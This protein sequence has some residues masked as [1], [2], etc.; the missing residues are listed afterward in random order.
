[1]LRRELARGTKALDNFNLRFKPHQ[2]YCFREWFESFMK[3]ALVE[4]DVCENKVVWP[5]YYSKGISIPLSF[6]D[7]RDKFEEAIQQTL[8]VAADLDDFNS[9]SHPDQ[10]VLQLK[11][12]TLKATYGQLVDLAHRRY[13]D[14]E[15]FWP[16]NYQKHGEVL[17][18]VSDVF[19]RSFSQLVSQVIINSSVL[20]LL[21]S[22][23]FVSSGAVQRP[24]GE[25]RRVPLQ[26]GARV[27]DDQPLRAAR[28]HGDRR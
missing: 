14:E 21:D 1:M 19:H 25:N 11:V 5:F 23:L 13:A 6:I 20:C 28:M 27:L 18:L 8:D 3:Q 4:H 2:A 17:T 16:N 26:T 10:K 15:R 22:L 12:D 7:D 9:G 24:A